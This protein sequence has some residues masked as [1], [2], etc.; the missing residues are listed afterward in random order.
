[1]IILNVGE[2]KERLSIYDDDTEILVRNES[3]DD[4]LVI[5][6]VFHSFTGEKIIVLNCNLLHEYL[7]QD[8]LK[9]IKRIP[10]K[11]LETI[12]DKEEQINL[13]L[14]CI[15][16]GT[17]DCPLYTGCRNICPNTNSKKCGCGEKNIWA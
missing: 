14:N 15:Y 6:N 12:Y 10:N 9:N 3:L 8:F 4:D 17:D 5:N 11:V 1:M 13:K 16:K 2:L 7:I